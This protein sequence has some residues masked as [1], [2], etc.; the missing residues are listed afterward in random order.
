MATVADFIEMLQKFYKPSDVVAF[1]FTD[2]DTAEIYL[3]GDLSDNEWEL[4]VRK[5]EDMIGDGGN[6]II[7]KLIPLI[8][9]VEAGR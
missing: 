6:D 8:D 9:N 5:Y 4:V 2:K 3:G 7:D 1:D